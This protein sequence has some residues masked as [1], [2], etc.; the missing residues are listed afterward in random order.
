M[1]RRV[2][3]RATPPIPGQLMFQSPMRLMRLPIYPWLLGIFPILHLYSVNFG[4]VIDREVAIC[5]FWMAVATTVAFLAIH[6]LLRDRHESALIVSVLS[7]GFSLSGHIHTLL[8]EGEMLLTWS[9]AVLIF[10]AAA[11]IELHKNRPKIDLQQIALP[12][13]LTITVLILLQVATLVTLNQAS[14]SEQLASSFGES[15]D[16]ARPTSAPIHDSDQY[17]D[18]YY[19][20]PDSYP[21]DAWHQSQSQYQ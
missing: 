9:A 2:Y 1:L 16:T 14:N 3:A 13:N 20:I 18:V 21:S 7:L 15:A 12:L 17:P 6:S 10:S 8:F 19:I 4:S 11:I 5:L